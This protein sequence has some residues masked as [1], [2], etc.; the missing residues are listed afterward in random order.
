MDKYCFVLNPTAGKGR[1]KKYRD[2]IEDYEKK[3]GV[4]YKIVET[5]YPGH[6]EILSRKACREGFTYIISVGGDGTL[7]EVVNGVYGESVSVGI[8]PCGTGN[9]FSRTICIP[10]NFKKQMDVIHGGN[11][12]WVDV[13]KANDRYFINVFSFGIDALI[14]RETQKIKKYLPGTFA[15]VAATIKML[16][17]YKPVEIHMESDDGVFNGKV[18]LV[19][20]GNGEYYGGGMKITP[21]ASVDSGDFQICIV[22]ALKRTKFLKLFPMVFSGKHVDREEVEVFRAKRILVKSNDK[23]LLNADGDIIGEC[24]VEV[25]LLPRS[26]KIIVP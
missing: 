11:E 5:E 21:G 10:T 24:P 6:G 14:T 16:M 13:G 2:R 8:I 20:F 4:E 12:K 1:G 17:T 7:F 19:A 23:V 26:I 22:K 25:N 9:D 15:Y 18:M 3:H